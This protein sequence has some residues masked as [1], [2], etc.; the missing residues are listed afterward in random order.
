MRVEDNICLRAED[1]TSLS[2]ESNTCLSVESNI[3]CRIGA[4]TCIRYKHDYNPYIV[5]YL[6]WM[7]FVTLI[8]GSAE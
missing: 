2:A 6:L 4:N 7:M 1:N 8:F 3:D 5:F